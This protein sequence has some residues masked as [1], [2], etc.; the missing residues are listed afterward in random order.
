[1]VSILERA[2]SILAEMLCWHLTYPKEKIQNCQVR[3]RTRMTAA[4][5]N[6][7]FSR[8]LL[9]KLKLVSTAGR[10]TLR[11]DMFSPPQLPVCRDSNWETKART[12]S[13]T[14][15]AITKVR[16]KGAARTKEKG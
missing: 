7:N 10:Q 12:I 1:M 8:V 9:L 4:N 5:S 15:D 6:T 3:L 2:I 16:E 13:E 14:G 11:V